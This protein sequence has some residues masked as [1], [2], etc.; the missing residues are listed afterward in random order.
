MEL[1]FDVKDQPD[2]SVEQRASNELVKLIR[3]LRWI[4]MEHEARQMQVVLQR[5]HPAATLL[6]GLFDRD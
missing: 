4:G 5:A 1:S 6:G 3:K 2:I